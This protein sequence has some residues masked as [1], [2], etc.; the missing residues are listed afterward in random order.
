LVGTK[1][2]QRNS[3][4]KSNIKT[5]QG[6][7]LAAEI[8]ATKYFEISTKN[9]QSME[10]VFQE[11]I[12]VYRI[13]PNKVPRANKK[14]TTSSSNGTPRTTQQAKTTDMIASKSA[15]DRKLG[16]KKSKSFLGIIQK[17]PEE[18]KEAKV[19]RK[20]EK[21]QMKAEKKLHKKQKVRDL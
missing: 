7:L 3:D 13:N 18:S 2:D 4:D 19:M 6:E 15:S 11:V 17:H 8:N 10:E 5:G 12:R 21:K 14:T 1:V 9:V 16:A 20:A